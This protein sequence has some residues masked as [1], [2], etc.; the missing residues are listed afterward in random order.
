MAGITGVAAVSVNLTV[1]AER[2]A[3]VWQSEERKAKQA[4]FLPAA[5]QLAAP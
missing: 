3:R 1:L 4:T 5:K 2:T